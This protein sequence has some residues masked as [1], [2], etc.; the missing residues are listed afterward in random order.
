MR[1]QPLLS[2]LLGLLLLLFAAR[3]SAQVDAERFKPAVTHDGWVNAEGSGTRSTADPWELGLF[4]NY[5]R[6]SLVAVDEDGDVSQQF[7]AG[8]MGVDFLASATLTRRFAL[9]LG[10]PLYLLQEG[11]GDPSFAGLGDLRLVPKLT[12]LD[13]RADGVGLALLGELR[14][15]T[16]TGDFAGGARNVT[17]V[18]RAALDHRFR[19]GVRIGFNAG[20]AIRER[21]DFGN[22]AAGSEFLYAGAL[23]YRFG[24]NAGNTEIGVELSGGVGFSQTDSEELPLEAFAFVRHEPSQEWEIMAGPGVGVLPG[25]GVP[26]FRVFAGVRYR[27]TSHDADQDGIADED[28]QCPNDPEDLDGDADS[29]GCPEEDPDA[30]RDGVADYQD[31]CPGEKETINGS[32]DEDGC[33]DSGSP[34]VIYEDGKFVVLDTIQFE[35]GS[36]QVKQE[37]HTTLDQLALIMKANPQFERIRV[38]GHSDDT[39]PRDVNMPLSRR[40][41]YAVRNHLIRRG[42]S[43]RRLTA[44]GFGPDR[45]VVDGTSESARAKNR[46]VEFVVGD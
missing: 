13:D 6:N 30:D 4:L 26:I 8:R 17:F 18:P 45:P 2:I 11:D 35:H 16:H 34:R 39:G 46:R 31:E 36:A 20:V 19:S 15:P 33:P 5:A 29:D 22:V 12:I 10:M 38:E 28:D 44:E 23:G 27:P 24:G 1:A 3:A 43:A 32:E 41:A 14:A 25:Y 9:G 42:V 40:R 37:S 21:T 7:V